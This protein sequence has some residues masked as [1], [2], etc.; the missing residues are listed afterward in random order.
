VRQPKPATLFVL[1]GLAAL[2][3]AGLAGL[4]YTQS[5]LFDVSA[6]RPHTVVTYWV[7]HRTMEHSVKVR[8]KAIDPPARFSPT[9]VAAGFCQF[10]RHCVTCHGAPAVPRAAWADGLNPGPPYLIDA[11]H[12]WNR[13]ELFQIVRGGIKMTGMPA[14]R[15]NLTDP[16]IWGVVAFVE[17]MPRVPPETYGRWRAERECGAGDPMP[18]GRE[19]KR[20]A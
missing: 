3:T 1:G 15:D 12:R 5:G 17:E 16:E 9:Q 13:A 7:V 6:T 20:A 10:E 2:A 4:L 14:W 11:S 18:V 19:R 8:A